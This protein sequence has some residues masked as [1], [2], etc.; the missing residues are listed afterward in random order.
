MDDILGLCFEAGQGHAKGNQALLNS[1]WGTQRCCFWENN[2][3][4]CSSAF[5]LN[6]RFGSA[7][8]EG[9]PAGEKG[10]AALRGPSHR[11]HVSE[12]L[13]PERLSLSFRGVCHAETA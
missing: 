3:Y 4:P 8:G 11:D 9:K 13:I 12:D 10:A 7:E 1:F 6:Q 5:V 2:A